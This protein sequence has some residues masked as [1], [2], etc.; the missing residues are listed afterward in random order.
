MRTDTA[1]FTPL[2]LLVG[3]S[4]LLSCDRSGTDQSAL[5][6]DQDDQTTSTPTPTPTGTPPPP[7][8][9]SPTPTPTLTPLPTPEPTQEATL[10][11][12]ITEDEA[13]ELGTMITRAIRCMPNDNRSPDDI[14]A[15]YRK[16]F[17]NPDQ[18]DSDFLRP[19]T[20]GLRHE[21]LIKEI[22][23]GRLGFK[24]AKLVRLIDDDTFE[25]E[26]WSWSQAKRD[27][28]S[29]YQITVKRAGGRLAIVKDKRIR[30]EKE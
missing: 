23:E 13:R 16:L 5:S 18:P 3:I 19:Y 10:P 30:T 11:G 27:I 28:R 8:T 25:I 26:L 14:F 7:S 29:R 4:V 1:A 20:S 12:P 6:N 17:I 24:G 9:A 15:A 21:R 2:I 22:S